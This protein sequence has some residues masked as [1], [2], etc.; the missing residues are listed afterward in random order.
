MPLWPAQ[1]HLLWYSEFL[2]A[3]TGLYYFDESV[4]P[5]FRL[6]VTASARLR[7]G[8]LPVMGTDWDSMPRL[9]QYHFG[10]LALDVSIFP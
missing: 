8:E 3:E 4:A 7:V 10:V 2:Q 6:F 5:T 1:V 9:W